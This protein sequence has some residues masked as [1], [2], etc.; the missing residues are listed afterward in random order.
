[1]VSRTPTC[2][3]RTVCKAEAR[4]HRSTD[5]TEN[6]A[7]MRPASDACCHGHYHRFI[8]THTLGSPVTLPA[9]HADIRRHA[10]LPSVRL[11][12]VPLACNFT[13]PH[14]RGRA[15][16]RLLCLHEI[17]GYY[18]VTYGTDGTGIC[19]H[20][21]LAQRCVDCHGSG[22]SGFLHLHSAT[23][24]CPVCV[25]LNQLSTISCRHHLFLSWEQL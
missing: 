21:R 20:K 10:V 25:G 9:A 11:R 5:A 12:P 1:M 19:T 2:G 7:R 17:D 13:A 14:N 22:I 8:V 24:R 16:T 18:C 23:V 15:L 4:H 6:L 3:S